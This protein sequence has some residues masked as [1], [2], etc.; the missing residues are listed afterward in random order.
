VLAPQWRA[1][2]NMLT[3]DPA[4]PSVMSTV[5]LACGPA[6]SVSGASSTP[7][8]GMAVFH[9]RL[10]P[11]G[12]FIP[13]VTSAGSLRWATAVASYRKNQANWSASKGLPATIRDAGSPHSNMVSAIA[14]AR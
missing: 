7:G 10:I 9:M 4:N 11:C 1:V 8:S 2:A 13:V 5:R 14:P 6:S 3:A 12:A